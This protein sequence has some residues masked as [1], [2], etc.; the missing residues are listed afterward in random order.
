MLMMTF[1]YRSKNCVAQSG[2]ELCARI[3]QRLGDTKLYP[4]DNSI[5]VSSVF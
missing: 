3:W 5:V 4:L 2:F 1:T